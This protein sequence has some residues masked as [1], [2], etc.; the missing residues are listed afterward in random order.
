MIKVAIIGGTGL[1]GSNLAKLLYKNYDIKAFSRAHSTNISGAINNIVD[2]NYLEDNLCSH[3]KEWSPDIIINT[4]AV[5]NLQQCENS[6]SMANYIN[7]DIAEQ[8][9]KVA[10][11]FDSYFIHVSTDHYFNDE[12]KLHNEEQSVVLLNNYAKSKYNAEKKVLK[13][14]CNVLVV[15][16]NIVGFRRRSAKSFFEWLLDELRGK[17]NVYLYSNFYTSPISVN[18]LGEVLMKCYK[19]SLTGVYNISSSEVI[20][21]YSFGIEVANKFGYTLDKI[22]PKELENDDSNSLKRALTLGL[23]VSKIEMALHIKMPTIKE[24]ITSLF[25]EHME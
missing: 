24:T 9:A 10:T 2:F 14:G 11:K 1:L 8:I 6:Y 15:R 17:D 20:D 5:V 7:S 19:A 3:F 23:D 13:A 25:N 18:Q 12:I 21:K 16:T 22:I 4:V